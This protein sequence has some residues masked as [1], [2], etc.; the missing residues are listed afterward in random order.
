MGFNFKA[1]KTKANPQEADSGYRQRAKQETDRFKLATDADF[2][3]SV[4]FKTK[5]DEEEF[6]KKLKLEEKRYFSGVEFAEKTKHLEN[7]KKGFPAK[8]GSHP[9]KKDPLASVDYTENL[10]TDCFLEAA[11]LLEAFRS[12]KPKEEYK[13]ATDSAYW[14]AVYFKS[15]TDK[16]KYLEDHCLLK[17]G[18]KYINGTAWLSKL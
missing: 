18:D 4:C 13:D 14:I 12:V 1:K 17:Y 5:K 11:A 10:E 2:W 7:T 16:D 9:A 8:I 6:R 15:Q 3:F